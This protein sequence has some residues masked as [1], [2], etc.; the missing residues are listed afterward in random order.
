[1][2]IQDVW[3]TA[4]DGTKLHAWLLVLRGWTRELKRTRPVIMFFQVRE[5]VG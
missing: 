1:M 4:A 5:S 3:L 2:A